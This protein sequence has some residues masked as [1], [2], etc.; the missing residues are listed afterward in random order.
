[1]VSGY[2]SGALNVEPRGIFTATGVTDAFYAVFDA[3]DGGRFVVDAHHFPGTGRG[4][5]HSAAVDAFGS[6]V[7]LG[8]FGSS[9]TLPSRTSYPTAGMLDVFVLKVS[10]IP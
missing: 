10:D 9:I 8:T 1:M 4:E 5:V 7:M 3:L 6:L 2:F